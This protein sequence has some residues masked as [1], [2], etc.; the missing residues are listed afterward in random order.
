MVRLSIQKPQSGWMYLTRP[1]AEH[2]LRPLDRARDLVGRL[3]L[4][5]LDVDDAEPEADLRAQIA[6]HRELLGRPVRG[7]HDDVIDMQRVEI[8]DQLAPTCPSGSIWPP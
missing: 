1:R 7:L 4:G 2:L 5:R 8:I 3:D 6:E